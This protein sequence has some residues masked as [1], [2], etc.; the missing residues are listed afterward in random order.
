MY[1]RRGGTICAHMTSW[2]GSTLRDAREAKGLS[3]AVFAGMVGV[4]PQAVAKWEAGLSTPTEENVLKI[5]DVL[6]G[7]PPPTTLSELRAVVQAQRE[8][9]LV[10]ADIVV[11]DRPAD[12]PIV[13][14]LAELEAV[15]GRRRDG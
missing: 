5:R 7:D 2:D 14:R 10:L 3:R 12:D 4:S 6:E 8:L 11:G 15:L 9:L 13:V 1:Q